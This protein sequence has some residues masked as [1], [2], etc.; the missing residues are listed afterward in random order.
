MN[1]AAVPVRPV[2]NSWCSQCGN[3]HRLGG[4]RAGWRITVIGIRWDQDALH[5]RCLHTPW[6]DQ[7][8]HELRCA[9][10]PQQQGVES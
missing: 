1:V 2:P 6:P 9:Q 10:L 8:L 7:A 4:D 5:S 3:R